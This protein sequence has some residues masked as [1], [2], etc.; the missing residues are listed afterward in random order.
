MTLC[1]HNI[2]A[3]GLL[4]TDADT[5]GPAACYLTWDR[6]SLDGTSDLTTVVGLVD[7]L[8]A[9]QVHRL[10]GVDDEWF[11]EVARRSAHDYLEIGGVGRLDPNV[12]D[13]TPVESPIDEVS[14]SNII[15]QMQTDAAVDRRVRQV[16]QQIRDRKLADILKAAYDNRCMF[17]GVALTVGIGPEQL[18]AEA[19]HIRPLGTPHD[20]PDVV[21]NM[22]VLCPNHHLQFDR[23]V[24]RLELRDNVYHLVSKVH[25]D[26][27][28][29]RQVELREDHVLE[30]EF[31][32]YHYDWHGNE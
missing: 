30:P 7:V 8:Q 13:A 23:G 4:N 19:A 29:G 6:L 1:G 3:A 2:D 16:Q 24:L 9:R 5:I 18:Y 17:C 26:D 28:N 20:G 25:G 22:L 14:L 10:L 32:K 27:L 31:V 12:L 21:A 11:D 15:A